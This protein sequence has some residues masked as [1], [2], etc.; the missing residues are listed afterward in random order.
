MNN[1]NLALITALSFLLVLCG[2]SREKPIEKT[3]TMLCAQATFRAA[4]RE[5][6]LEARR[7]FYEAALVLRKDFSDTSET[8]R[9]NELAPWSTTRAV[10]KTG[11]GPSVTLGGHSDYPL[12][13]G[14]D[15]AS[16]MIIYLFDRRPVNTVIPCGKHARELYQQV[17]EIMSDKWTV[18]DAGIEP[19][20][21]GRP[22][23]P[24]P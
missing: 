10:I 24:T 15:P 1:S 12:T 2:C 7:H 19:H 18:T 20:P 4:N 17:I 13:N 22:N 6:I 14:G 9:G 23:Q 11:F 5:D 8:S 3:P 16:D 21:L